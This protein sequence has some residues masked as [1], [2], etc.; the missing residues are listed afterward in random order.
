[1]ERKN[2]KFENKDFLK[3]TSTEKLIDYITSENFANS[4][5]RD[6][7]GKHIWEPYVRFREEFDNE[8]SWSTYGSFSVPEWLINETKIQDILNKSDSRKIDAVGIIPL[9]WNINNHKN[10]DIKP[11]KPYQTFVTS[12]YAADSADTVLHMTKNKD[13]FLKLWGDPCQVDQ[14]R[15]NTYNGSISNEF[16]TQYA[17]KTKI[18]NIRIYSSFVS[19]S[20]VEYDKELWTFIHNKVKNSS[21]TQTDI[22]KYQPRH[23][24]QTEIINERLRITERN[25]KKSSRVLGWDQI[26]GGVGKTPMSA[27]YISDVY[28]L[29]FDKYLKL[30]SGCS[31]YVI[32]HGYHNRQCLSQ[33][34]QKKLKIMRGENVFPDTFCV[35]RATVKDPETVPYPQAINPQEIAN[36]IMDALD[37]GTPILN[38][39]YLYHHSE[40]LEKSLNIVRKKFPNFNPSIRWKDELDWPIGSL[41]SA[42]VP[43]YDVRH[44]K[45]VI[46]YGDTATKVENKINGMNRIKVV[47]TQN[48][49]NTVNMLDAAEMGLTKCPVIHVEVELMSNIVNMLD[50]AGLKYKTKKVHGV[51]IP[52]VDSYVD[53]QFI[54]DNGNRKYLTLEE[55]ITMIHIMKVLCNN[56]TEMNR[57]LFT[58]SRHKSNDL[59]MKN[60]HWLTRV[61]FKNH[62]A[63][64][65]IDHAEY[66]DTDTGDIGLKV[67]RHI[68]KCVRDLKRSAEWFVSR[69][70]RGFDVPPLN[71]Y[72]PLSLKTFRT[73]AQEWMRVFR[74]DESSNNAHMIFSAIVN[75][76]DPKRKKSI[77]HEIIEK[78][79]GLAEMGLPVIDYIESGFKS[80]S[81]SKG[82]KPYHPFKLNLPNGFSADAF[83]QVVTSNIAYR[84]K[85]ITNEYIEMHNWIRDRFLLLDNPNDAVQYGALQREAVAKFESLVLVSITPKKGK[86]VSNK[87]K[88][89]WMSSFMWGIQRFLKNYDQ[90]QNNV[91]IMK[92]FQKN[93]KN[94]RQSKMNRLSIVVRMKADEPC[95]KWYIEKPK[96][97]GWKEFENFIN[98]SEK[99]PTNNSAK[100]FWGH[101]WYGRTLVWERK[102]KSMF[103]EE[104]AE[105]HK[106]WYLL[107]T[108]RI[109]D[110]TIECFKWLIN[111]KNICSRKEFEKEYNYLPS[112]FLEI[113]YF[114]YYLHDGIEYHHKLHKILLEN[115]DV[116]N[117]M[118]DW[119]SKYV[120]Q[121]AY[122]VHTR[123]IFETAKY[124]YTNIAP[125]YIKTFSTNTKINSKKTKKRDPWIVQELSR[126]G[127]KV[128][129]TEVFRT[130]APFRGKKIGHAD[131]LKY[132]RITKLN[133]GIRNRLRYDYTLQKE[134]EEWAKEFDK[135]VDKIIIQAYSN[136]KGG[137]MNKS[138][139]LKTLG[140]IPSETWKVRCESIFG[141]GIDLN[142]NPIPYHTP[143][144]G[145]KEKGITRKSISAQGL[146]N[147]REG[148]K[149]RKKRSA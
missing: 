92:D 76:L 121:L 107:R 6:I 16:H 23:K 27:K 134:M 11:N 142:P 19:S 123:D 100:T 29:Y 56:P 141:P 86:A 41:D 146:Q 36:N 72:A 47:G 48:H 32:L 58:N 67:T 63:L 31:T 50:N 126:Q 15:L 131:V 35:T 105:Q 101:L 120:Q 102:N 53:T 124:W 106:E 40:N 108:N 149:N 136:I 87:S 79:E 52:D 7:R 13:D 38:I 114:S 51:V 122:P 109:I 24:R 74:L 37:I 54:V 110:K 68:S 61:I 28:N 84:N 30:R 82:K 112:T 33:N 60:F 118:K 45:A 20:S 143:G 25:L 81:P 129:E 80:K 9:G 62:P 125:P 119:Q 135:S 145:N 127:I 57:I 139:V 91:K 73:Q 89:N 8:K 49:N 22:E 4:T 26:T 132:E 21:Y 96:T 85:F 12:E 78:F 103:S 17:S 90:I 3:F 138:K 94:D 133:R 66:Q 75:D 99:L 137:K 70:S 104:I 43:G 144:V 98:Q 97:S 55:L 128:S 77:K 148:I 113:L 69:A 147:I 46:D 117:A 115:K 34:E 44:M 95:F 18:P 71:T 130:L 64:L 10:W 42:Y 65:N 93:F 1:M 88:R 39:P 116:Q 2:M 5:A 14:F 59:F 111:Q 83:K 140:G